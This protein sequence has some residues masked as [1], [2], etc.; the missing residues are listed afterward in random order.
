MLFEELLFMYLGLDLGTSGLKAV[1]CNEEQQIIA[2]NN[3]SLSVSRPRPKWSEQ[4]PQDWW[5]ATV[6]ALNELSKTH[7]SELLQVKSIGLAG[8]MHGAVLLDENGDVLRPA[9]LWNDVRSAAECEELEELEPEFKELSGNPIFPGFTAPKLLWVA[10]HEPKIFSKIAKVLLPKDYLRFRLSGEYISEMSDAAG[11]LWLDIDKRQWS[12]K[13]L[14]VTKLNISHMPSLVEGSSQGGRISDGIANEFGLQKDVI[15]AGGAGDNAGGAIGVGAV[16]P[17]QAFISLGTSGVIF[18]CNETF[19][20]KPQEAVHSFCHALPNSWHQMSVMLNAA[21]CLDWVA[22]LTNSK[23]VPTL[24]TEIDA[25]ADEPSEVIFLPYL[26][27][28][29]T[30]HNNA[31]AKGV[32]FGMSATTTSASLGLAVLEGVA[33]AFADG[34]DSL[35]NSGAKIDRISLIGGGGRSEQWAQILADV[36]EQELICHEDSESGPAFGAARLARLAVTGEDFS[37][38]CTTPP[39]KNII[40]PNP[41]KQPYYH[42]RLKRFRRLYQ[43]LKSEFSA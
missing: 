21:S 30:P 7:P 9:I 32:F 35:L 13:L 19:L 20:P 36:L 5:N 37:V 38:V 8:Q 4:D 15:I 10:K 25:I 34:L 31:D 16:S 41:D 27:G 12:E 18:L 29:R 33:F 43:S 14:A 22:N 23:D 6:S 42:S 28:E 11:T 2:Q 1:L 39:V 17:G 3:V 40:K 24:L 26:T